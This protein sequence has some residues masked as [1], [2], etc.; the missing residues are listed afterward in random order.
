[1][2]HLVLA[3][4]VDAFKPEYLRHAPFLRGLA[5]HGWTGRLREDF[6]FVPRAAY[7]GGLDAGAYGF[8]N[9]FALDPSAS[10]FRAARGLPRVGPWLERA[11]SL[12]HILE[13]RARA[14]LTPFA[15]HYAAT[16]A[17]PFDV[18]PQF[19]PVE[20]G[21]PW[22]EDAGYP[23]IFSI[24]RA[25]GKAFYTMAW[26]ETN[27]LEDH[28][29]DGIVAA[30]LDGLSLEHRFAFVHL[31]QLDAL[32]HAHGPG[33]TEVREGVART[34]RLLERLMAVVRARYS[35]VDL[36]LFGDHGMVPVTRHLDLGPT[37][38]ATGLRVCADYQVF[39]DSTMA[40]FWYFHEGARQRLNEA[41]HQV[42]GGHLLSRD[43]LD[44]HGLSRCDPR[45]GEAYFLADPGVLL[46]PNY[47]QAEHPVL[48]MH[49]YVPDCP[50]NEGLVLVDRHGPAQE[51]GVVRASDVCSLLAHLLE[52]DH[53]RAHP[54]VVTPRVETRAGFTACGV[55]AAEALVAAQLARVVTTV[56]ETLEDVEAIVL[57]GSFGR[58]EGSV[59]QD[60]QGWRAVND[61]DV[62]V[63]A[64][65]A[66]AAVLRAR[67]HALAR[68][69]GIDF[70]HFAVDDGAWADLPATMSTYDRRYGSRVIHGD[71]AVCERLPAYAPA[72]IP[73]SEGLQLLFNRSA[74]LLSTWLEVVPQRAARS[75][76]GAPYIRT[77]VAKALV[78]IG[79]WHLLQW[80]AYDASYRIRRQRFRWLAPGAGLPEPLLTAV[81]SGYDVKL[82]EP[83]ATVLPR[84]TTA[85]LLLDTLRA[86]V[87]QVTHRPAGTLAHSMDA[88]T[89]EGAASWPQ[90]EVDNANLA[91]RLATLGP[92]AATHTSIRHQIYAS[93]AM[94]LDASLH[95]EGVPTTHLEAVFGTDAAS[96]DLSAARALS[97]RAWF[98]IAL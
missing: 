18:L 74:G 58:G 64:P 70:V 26:P 2:T 56:L 51:L 65:G 50:D 76:P 4:L 79:D 62:L 22:R 48:G 15:A 12:R 75:R 98:A 40:R 55:P 7:F 49:G 43:E 23:S 8:T 45:N 95:N 67:E 89:T 34:D 94:L 3:V 24:L 52:I 44:A 47:F 80:K 77:Q 46:F 38:S 25:Q 14:L 21:A 31:Q 29:D 16:A 69:F 83:D 82:D 92:I 28:S 57:E 10:P 33:S 27:G 54:V 20:T 5:S 90:V 36:L 78:A 42:K 35:R 39:V 68:E 17:I 93:I 72:D 84:E 61:Y 86:A 59:Q 53:P 88:Y 41:L 32:G 97:A 60:A 87:G 66:D 1:M 13:S 63:V 81:L 37:L 6:G 71:V 19:A 91:I 9:M 85:A 30:V 73:L 96:L 11:G